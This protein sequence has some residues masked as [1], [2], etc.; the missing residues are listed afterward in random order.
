MTTNQ[1]LT[2]PHKDDELKII[3]ATKAADDGE[4]IFWCKPG[5]MTY[6]DIAGSFSHISGGN[7]N[8]QLLGR[9]RCVHQNSMSHHTII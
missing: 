7:G 8:V 6:N 4:Q 1:K 2:L 5:D 3:A 9:T